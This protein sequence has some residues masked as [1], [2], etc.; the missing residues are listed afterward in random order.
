MDLPFLTESADF[1]N[2]ILGLAGGISVTWLALSLAFKFRLRA[3]KKEAATLALNRSRRVLKGQAAEQLAPLSA[4]FPYLPN[5]ARFLGSPIDYIVFDG[6]SDS[7]DVEIIFVEI[8]SGQAKLSERERRVRDAIHKGR[9]SWT[10][11]RL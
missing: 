10:E 11:L 5:D 7:G 3:A 1:F 4:G 6:L 8:K 9:V 2:I